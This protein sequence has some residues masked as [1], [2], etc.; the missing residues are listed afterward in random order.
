M[1]SSRH[2]AIASASRAGEAEAA[3]GAGSRTDE[4]RRHHRACVQR[5]DR[6][7]RRAHALIVTHAVTLDA[8]DDRQ[9]EPMAEAARKALGADSSNLV[10]DTGYSNGELRVAKTPGSSHRCLR[11]V[12]S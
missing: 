10:A 3:P 6:S 9:L 4:D 1:K 7:G 12:R 8:A 2:R 5:A 11:H